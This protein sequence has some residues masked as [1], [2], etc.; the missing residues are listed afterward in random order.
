MLA[1]ELIAAGAFLTG[2]TFGRYGRLGAWVV[3]ATRKVSP[4]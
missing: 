2:I 3:R 4:A 1:L